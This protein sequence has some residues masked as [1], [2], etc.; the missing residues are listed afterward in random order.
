M[1]IGHLHI[2]FGKPRR[3]FLTSQVGCLCSALLWQWHLHLHLY[4]ENPSSQFCPSRCSQSYGRCCIFFYNCPFLQC[5]PTV[6]ICF[7]RILLAA[8]RGISFLFFFFFFLIFYFSGLCG[9]CGS[10]QHFFLILF[11]YGCVGSSFLCEGFL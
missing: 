11:I 7:R 5:P 10:C 9:V 8:V 1:P 2:F 4:L 6:V 3:F